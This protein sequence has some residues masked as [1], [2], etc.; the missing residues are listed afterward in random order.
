MRISK[1]LNLLKI[2]EGGGIVYKRGFKKKIQKK[3]LGF[4]GNYISVVSNY[5][6]TFLFFNIIYFI[7]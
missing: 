3:N 5:L 4:I 7:V 1:R 6:I 2:K